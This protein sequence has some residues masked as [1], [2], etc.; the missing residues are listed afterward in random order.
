MGQSG[1]AHINTDEF[2]LQPTPENDPDSGDFER[3]RVTCALVEQDRFLGKITAHLHALMPEKS[4]TNL[5]NAVGYFY[6]YHSFPDTPTLSELFREKCCD[7][8]VEGSEKPL[9]SDF[10]TR[11]MATPEELRPDLIATKMGFVGTLG[12]AQR[13]HMSEKLQECLDLFPEVL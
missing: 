4:F 12:C 7:C 9:K 8:S 3:E 6:G 1:V 10:Y 11:L 13:I 2:N 5:G